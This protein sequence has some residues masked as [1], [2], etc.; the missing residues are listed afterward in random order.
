MFGKT[1]LITAT[2][3]Q[4]DEHEGLGIGPYVI[5]VQPSSV[6]ELRILGDNNE[7]ERQNCRTR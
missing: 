7:L 5:F 3:K 4:R 6:N 2:D 1:G